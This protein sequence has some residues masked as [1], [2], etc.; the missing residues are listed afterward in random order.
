MNG[1]TDGRMEGWMLAAGSGKAVIIIPAAGRERGGT[2]HDPQMAR[3]RARTS[4]ERPLL[5][6][7][8]GIRCPLPSERPGG[9]KA[10]AAPRVGPGERAR[11]GTRLRGFASSRSTQRERGLGDPAKGQI[12]AVPD[13][14]DS[15]AGRG[16]RPARLRLAPRSA[17]PRRACLL[18][19]APF[20]LRLTGGT[21]R[22]RRSR[23]RLARTLPRGGGAA[24]GGGGGGAERRAALAGLAGL[25]GWAV[26]RTGTTPRFVIQRTQPTPLRFR[27]HIRAH[28]RIGTMRHHMMVVVSQ[29]TIN[30]RPQSRWLAV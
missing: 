27:E 7:M 19:S 18:R 1:R 29:R 13:P 20:P 9:W 2:R 8:T 4:P 28:R 15:P 17:A 14:A 25:L 21:C 12:R 10:R 30:G 6:P 5:G 22:Y 24:D 16:P 23:W 26:G 11:V 3:E